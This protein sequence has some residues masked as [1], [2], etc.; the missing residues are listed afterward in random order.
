MAFSTST[1]Q[2]F[3]EA[4]IASLRA[5]AAL[6]G[7]QVVDGP[8]G[9]GAGSDLEFIA[10]LNTKGQVSVRALN[11]TTQPRD[12]KYTTDVLFYASRGAKDQKTATERAFILYAEL[13]KLLREDPTLDATYTGSGI[14]YSAV[15]GPI[16]VRKGND[17]QNRTT[18]ILAGVDVHAR[19]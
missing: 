6:N 17:G 18:G 15:V 2:A 3:T 19:L 11:R 8:P 1:V 12:E 14:I 9:P 4:L 10:V 7:V 13:E 16:E 5:R